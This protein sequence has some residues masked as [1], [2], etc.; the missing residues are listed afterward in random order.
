MQATTGLDST[1]AAAVVTILARLSAD[2]V[3]VALSIHQPRLDIFAMLSHILL[4]SSEG[5]MVYSGPAGSAQAHFAALGHIAPSDVNI[6]DFLLDVTIRASP[7]VCAT[8]Y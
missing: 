5:R 3:T 1:S 2:G 7:Q 4:L 6:A 8:P